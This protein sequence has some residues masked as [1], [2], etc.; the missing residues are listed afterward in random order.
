MTD[1]TRVL[2]NQTCPV[3][4]FEIHHYRD[5]ADGTG[6]P[7][8]FDDLMSDDLAPWGLTQDEAAKRLYVLHEGALLSGIPGFIV[9]WEQMPRY[10]WLAKIVK[11]P[12][13]RHLAIATYDYVLAPLIYGWHK[14]RLAR[15]SSETQ[16]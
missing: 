3:C 5:Y 9:L 16:S 1:D 7:I 15:L 12:G 6:L 4:R 2:Y 14:R 10:R 11:Q 8:R 13:I